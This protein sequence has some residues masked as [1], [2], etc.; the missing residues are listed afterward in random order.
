M[1]EGTEWLIPYRPYLSAF[2]AILSVCGAVLF[3]YAFRFRRQNRPLCLMF[4]PRYW[5][6]SVTRLKRFLRPPGFAF[7]MAGW[8]LLNV[9]LIWRLMFVGWDHWW[10]LPWP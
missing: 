1:I 6:P 5:W 7:L 2:T 10:S 3:V 8:Y 9:G 4:K